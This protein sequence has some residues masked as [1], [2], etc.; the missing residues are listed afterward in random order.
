M[1]ND[2]INWNEENETAKLDRLL[3]KVCDGVKVPSDQDSEDA[4]NQQH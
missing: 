3:D 2:E 4:Y 1:N